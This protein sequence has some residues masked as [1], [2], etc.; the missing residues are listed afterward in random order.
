MPLIVRYDGVLPANEKRNRVVSLTDIFATLCDFAGISY[1][2]GSAQDSV[3]FANYLKSKDNK[4]LRKWL[5]TWLYH[6]NSKRKA[7]AIRTKNWKAITKFDPDTGNR[8]QELYNLATDP[9]E[10]NNLAQKEEYKKDMEVMFRRLRALGPCPIQHKTP[11]VLTSGPMKG[12]KVSCSFF[13]IK[14]R[15]YEYLDG[16]LKCPLQCGRHQKLCER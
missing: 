5:P 6:N 11:F 13:N 14:K 10:K 9:W 8:T 2:E 3:S 1:P 15:C 7:E 12:D 16:E 4:N